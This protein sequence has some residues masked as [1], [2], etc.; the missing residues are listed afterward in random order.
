MVFAEEDAHRDPIE[1]FH[2]W[3][4][5][6]RE[7]RE[8]LPESMALA[9]SDKQGRPSVRFV[10]FREIDNRGFV[11]Y[12]NYNSRKAN[13]LLENPRGSIA[14]H[15]LQ[16]KRQIRIEGHV[17]RIDGGESDSYF[18]NRPRDAQLEAWASHQS[19]TIT[20]RAWLDRRWAKYDAQFREKVPRPDWWGGYRLLPDA[21]EFW[22]QGENRLHDRLLYEKCEDGGWSLTR[23]AP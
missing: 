20:D 21:M 13:E 11:F 14:V 12:T 1:Q 3:F 22:Q 8:P 17:E 10:M 4:Q 2:K 15:W 6:A 5:I 7:T 18:E 19:E 23:L 9:T 16:S